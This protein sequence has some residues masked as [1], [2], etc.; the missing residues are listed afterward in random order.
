MERVGFENILKHVD[1]IHK[2]HCGDEL[3]VKMPIV[4]QA[5]GFNVE[6]NEKLSEVI[7]YKSKP[8]ESPTL[9]FNNCCLTHENERLALLIG[10]HLY[11]ERV[12]V[13][14]SVKMFFDVDQKKK[15][16]V[17]RDGKIDDE[18]AELVHSY[19]FALVCPITYI[20]STMKGFSKDL[21]MAIP[22]LSIIFMTIFLKSMRVSI[23]FFSLFTDVVNKSDIFAAGR[24]ALNEKIKNEPKLK[25]FG[26]FKG[27]DQMP[28]SI[29]DNESFFSD[30]IGKSF[31]ANDFSLNPDKWDRRK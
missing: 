6:E 28:G 9:R 1:S 10:Y 18:L 20:R 27:F 2:T 3:P 5:M 26:K 31:F 8:G 12:G 29:N 4:A 24:D 7:W 21:F 13:Y 30:E 23:P 15:L 11:C 14:E 19:A 17:W 16:I 22:Q 25:E